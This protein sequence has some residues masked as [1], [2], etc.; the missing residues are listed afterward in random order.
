MT[1]AALRR[2]L[3]GVLIA[4]FLVAIALP[5]AG[6]LLPREGSFA[7]TEN[8]RPAPFP[9]VRLTGPGWGWS[10][11]SFPARFE[12][13]WNDS[14][15]FRWYMIRAHSVAKLALGA[16]PSAK[17]VVGSE[18]FLYYAAD[19]SLDYFR[20]VKPFTAADL[21]RWRLDLERRQRWL[22]ERGIR[23]LV[24]VAPNKETIYPE[25]MPAALHP[26][27]SESRLDQ[28]LRHLAARSSVE[29]LD[30]RAPLLEAKRRE[31]VYHRTD[32]HWND[33]GAHVAA[34]ALLARLHAWFPEIPATPLPGAF[35]IRAGPGGDLARMLALEDRFPEAYVEWRPDAPDPSRK[36]DPGSLPRGLEVHECP[37][38]AGPVVF[39]QQDSFNTAL[40]PFIASR[41]RRLV[42]V[43]GT[44][45]AEP[46]IER[47]RPAVVV[48]QF[49][50]RMLTCD[51]LRCAR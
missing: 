33:A 42:R 23:Y 6:K 14:F 7:L 40:A 20:A 50:E 36:L 5:L 29:V 22:A 49:V 9:T 8:R 19:D 2:V 16:S 41:V 43:D 10:L 39:M 1:S 25:H 30:L 18:G 4:V 21:E 28:L 24:V 27:R 35:A 31:R 45:L 11:T 37:T 47:E 13:W 26:V 17:A 12:R 44:R 3:E 51:D 15:A 34:A 32:T 48:Q 46:L 38:C